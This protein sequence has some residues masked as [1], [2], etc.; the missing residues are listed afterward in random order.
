MQHNEEVS[1]Q[2]NTPILGTYR[3]R[4]EVICWEGIGVWKGPEILWEMW[5]KSY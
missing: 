1:W 4:M 3:T 5:K 2:G